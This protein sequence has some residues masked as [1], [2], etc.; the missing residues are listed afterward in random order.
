LKLKKKEQERAKKAQNMPPKIKSV[1]VLVLRD[2]ANTLVVDNEPILI[3][4]TTTI[5]HENRSIVAPFRVYVTPRELVGVLNDLT[6]AHVLTFQVSSSGHFSIDCPSVHSISGNVLTTLGFDKTDLGCGEKFAAEHPFKHEAVKKHTKS[7]I[8]VP[9]VE[10]AANKVPRFWNQQVH[11]PLARPN[12]KQRLEQRLQEKSREQFL[13]DHLKERVVDELRGTS[14]EHLIGELQ[15]NLQAQ[16]QEEE[17]QEEEQ[18]Q[19]EQE[20]QEPRQAF[21]A[22]RLA[23]GLKVCK[24]CG[25][26]KPETVYYSTA[27]ST[28]AVCP[29]CTNNNRP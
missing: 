22:V 7:N 27:T 13:I 26:A 19:E 18:L 8:L 9:V 10:F 14:Q 4:A 20:L 23:N 6:V 21:R 28:S 12:K 3:P 29:T 25:E 5:E 15:A 2:G 16:I 24:T 11:Q 17:P 1:N